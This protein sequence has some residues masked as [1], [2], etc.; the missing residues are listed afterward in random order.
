MRVINIFLLGCVYFFV[1]LAIN[2]CAEMNTPENDYGS[3][4]EHKTN[5]LDVWNLLGKPNHSYEL[6][7]RCSKS[8]VCYIVS[9]YVQPVRDSWTSSKPKYENIHVYVFNSNLILEKYQKFENCNIE[10]KSCDQSINAFVDV[11]AR[12]SE[13][14]LEID[15]SK[16]EAGSSI[17]RAY[18]KTN[19]V[20][21]FVDDGVIEEKQNETNNSAEENSDDTVQSTESNN[22][23][24]NENDSMESFVD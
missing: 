6:D 13:K 12:R 14:M 22:M 4:V 21:N 19:I 8:N 15:K 18:L 17:K 16:L 7:K 9:A 24:F 11:Y 23:E 20:D 10:K 1:T 3:F 2:G 5:M